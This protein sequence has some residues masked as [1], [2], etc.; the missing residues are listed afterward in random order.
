MILS[1]IIWLF[2][3]TV[4]LTV[5]EFAHA[6]IADRLGDPTARVHGRLSL[7]PRDHYDPVGTTMLIVTSVLRALGAPVIPFGWAKP[8]MFDP[9]NLQNAKRDA[10]LIALS[11]PAMNLAT[12]LILSI[13]VRTFFM[14]IPLINLL[15]IAVITVNVA[16]AAFNLIPVHPLDGS[17]VLYG[18]L[19]IDLADEYDQIMS[20]YGTMLLLFLILP[21]N[22]TSAI[23]S[24]ISPLIQFFLNLLLP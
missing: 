23:T 8:V 1:L 18:L 12:A 24:L 16:L 19:P 7:N 3:V 2:A 6:L 15:S 22:G 11:G 14:E 4:A 13:L 5:H 10:A 21:F 9:Y 20:R 17:K